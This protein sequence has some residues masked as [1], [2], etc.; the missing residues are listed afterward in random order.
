M[1]EL[2]AGNSPRFVLVA[3]Q[4]GAERALKAEFAL[5][6]PDTRPA[7]SRPGFVTFKLADDGELAGEG[8]PEVDRDEPPVFARA[9]SSSIKSMRGESSQQLASLVADAARER[10][11]D[12]LHVWPRDAT[13]VGRRGYEPGPTPASLEAEALLRAAHAERGL[14]IGS[15]EDPTQL[16]NRVLDV[17]MVEPLEWHVGQHVAT[18]TTGCWPGGVPSVV[19]P[20]HA[21][22]RAYLKI[23]E[24]IRWSGFRLR[25]G[26]RCAEIGCSPGGASQA[27]LDRGLKVMGI[28]PAAVAPAL[29]ENS[30]FTHVCKRGAEVR[31]REFRNVDWLTADINVAPQ[32]T[33]D[34]VAAIVTHPTVAIRGLLLTLK[35]LE[36]ELAAEIPAY[37]DR[38]RSWGYEHVAARQLAYNRQEICVAARRGG[39]Q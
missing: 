38:V 37:L 21:V 39:H 22:S 25:K 5:R 15:S 34:T 27:L 2:G 11:F 12:R 17:V 23:E 13:A 4:V 7:F 29:L 1:A 14:F 31:R 20:E 26:Q 8:V 3:C 32:Y 18:T 35:L 9:W 16:G 36:W 28:D 6:W 19:L 24:A 10:L 30:N 33:L